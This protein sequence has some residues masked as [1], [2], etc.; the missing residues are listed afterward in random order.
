MFGPDISQVGRCRVK[1]SLLL[2]A[3]VLDPDEG[4]TAKTFGEVNKA[5]TGEVCDMFSF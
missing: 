1:V 3:T 4:K 5:C 2:E